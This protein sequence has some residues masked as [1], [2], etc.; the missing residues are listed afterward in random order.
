MANTSRRRGYTDNTGKKM[1]IPM[2]VEGGIWNE[3]FITTPKFV[4]IVLI[5][6][7]FVAIIITLG[8]E[9]RHSTVLSYVVYLGL[10]A[11]VS[12]LVLRFIVFEEKFY[13]KMYK[14]LEKY[15]TSSPAL[16]WNISSIKDTEYGAIVTYSD[17]R[18]GV[19]VRMQRDTIT[20]KRD[21][22]DEIHY[23]A[24][25]DFYHD[26]VGNRYSFVQMNIMEQAGK[27]PRLNEL[28]KLVTKN[29]NPSIQKLMELEIGYIKNI[30]NKSLY[31]SDYFLFYTTDMAKVDVI[32]DEI[33]ECCLGLQN[34]A[35]TGFEILGSIGIVDLVKEIYAVNYFN[36]TDASLMMFSNQSAASM[37]PLMIDGIVWTDG[38]KQKLNNV[39][40]AKARRLTSLVIDGTQKVDDISLKKA[41]Y[42]KENNNNGI[43]LDDALTNIRREN[44]KVQNKKQEAG[45]G[46]KRPKAN[47]PSPVKPIK[48]NTNISES[49]DNIEKTLDPNEDYIDF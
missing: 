8:N 28:S 46:G 6:L 26:V 42:K 13:Y 37:V 35:F 49:S 4:C 36:A 31:E 39:D 17:A 15:E 38:N 47:K 29:K 7:A 3:H 22:F 44:R 5:A 9:D 14:E 19:F 2:N 1:F 33:S 24:F 12:S 30:T 27:D 41:L 40:R 18:I 32:I 43:D 20:G 21:G 34:G 48:D 25:S 23:D 16:F 45:I 10:W 11:F